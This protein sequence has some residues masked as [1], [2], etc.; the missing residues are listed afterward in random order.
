M[1]GALLYCTAFKCF[2]FLSCCITNKKTKKVTVMCFAANDESDKSKGIG[3]IGDFEEYEESV[4]LSIRWSICSIFHLLK[5]PDNKRKFGQY[6]WHRNALFSSPASLSLLLVL[7]SFWPV[8]LST[9][10]LASSRPR[11]AMTN[12][13]CVGEIWEPRSI[14]CQMKPRHSTRMILLVGSK[15]TFKYPLPTGNMSLNH[16]TC[17]VPLR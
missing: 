8:G 12:F 1:T 9:V 4:G 17:G 7:N 6:H 13:S 16:C 15:A 14:N 3:P 5:V 2:I 10:R 11:W